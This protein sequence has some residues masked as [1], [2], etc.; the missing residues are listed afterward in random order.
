MGPELPLVCGT[1]SAA[2]S[3][4]EFIALGVA[5]HDAHWPNGFGGL[6]GE[7]AVVNDDPTAHAW[8]RL[9]RKG[10]GGLI[11]GAHQGEALGADFFGY[12]RRSLGQGYGRGDIAGQ[13][14]AKQAGQERKNELEFFGHLGILLGINDRWFWGEM[15]LG[16]STGLFK[17]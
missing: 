15:E 14:S 11:V 17:P 4:P 12:G 6:V 9:G 10:S 8:D 2:S 3:A 13:Y 16:I 5:E 1:D 7:A